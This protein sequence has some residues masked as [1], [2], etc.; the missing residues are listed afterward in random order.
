[1]QVVSLKSTYIVIPLALD[2]SPINP[3]LFLAQ[4]INI[5][6]IP[7]LKFSLSR[8]HIFSASHSLYFSVFL[9]LHLSWGSSEKAASC[10]KRGKGKQ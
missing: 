8:S 6:L 10:Q 9:A 4:N 3:F 5:L 7:A 2:V 1:M